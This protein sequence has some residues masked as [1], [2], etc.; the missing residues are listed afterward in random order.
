[1]LLWAVLWSCLQAH[2]ETWPKAD[3]AGFDARAA[4]PVH[5]LRIYSQELNATGALR[6]NGRALLEDREL[7]G[8]GGGRGHS[9]GG[10]GHLGGRRGGGF[11]SSS[12]GAWRTAGG[13]GGLGAMALIIV[14][15]TRRRRG[16]WMNGNESDGCRVAD[17]YARTIAHAGMG[18]ASRL[19]TDGNASSSS[20]AGD[21]SSLGTPALDALCD[22]T[23]GAIS[24]CNACQDCASQS[25]M[26]TITNCSVFLT[27]VYPTCLTEQGQGDIPWW[28]FIIFCVPIIYLVCSHIIAPAQQQA[29]IPGSAR[30]AE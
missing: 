7:R 30:G 14:A 4:D 18:I 10:R 29:P 8:F 11:H 23:V 19:L 24:S 17:D 21:T 12:R 6:F 20:G 27:E 16:T 1:M 25:C 2:A 15:S 5:R 26:S 3:A 22:R 13:V 9:F 28:V